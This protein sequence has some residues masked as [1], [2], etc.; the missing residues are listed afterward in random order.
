MKVILAIAIVALMAVP[1]T[2]YGYAGHYDHGYAYYISNLP[3]I[4]LKGTN[5]SVNLTYA[6]I[7][8]YLNGTYFSADMNHVRWTTSMVN[9]TSFTYGGKVEFFP[10][11]SYF[12]SLILSRM[13]DQN[14][15]QHLQRSPFAF[16]GRDIIRPSANVK[17][18]I[19]QSTTNSIFGLGNDTGSHFG[20]Y[21]ITFSL[22]SSN[23]NG[24]GTLGLF[25]A[26]GASRPD[27]RINLNSNGGVSYVNEAN[28]SGLVVN[29]DK[30]NAS[31]W[32][33]NT[34]QL[35]GNMANLSYAHRAIGPFSLVV[36]RYNFTDG[37]HSIVQDPYFASPQFNFLIE[38]FPVRIIKESALFLADHIKLLVAGLVT[39][40]AVLGFTFAGFML[41]PG[42]SADKRYKIRRK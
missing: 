8:L 13:L 16:S 12:Q 32:W 3:E 29:S 34:Y 17:I 41:G 37:I 22:T 1:A 24:S 11:Y 31:Y 25:Q 9:E 20:A 10:V 4:Y 30:I 2:S 28:F 26:L 42:R 5:G 18:E 33:S 15:P 19:S 27:G 23:I 40:G 39:G 14:A 21:S 7:A 38:H 35:N 36:F 6:E